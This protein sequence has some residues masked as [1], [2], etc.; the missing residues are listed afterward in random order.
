MDVCL[1]GS[2][3][4]P[5]RRQAAR[6]ASGFGQQCSAASAEPFQSAV[7]IMQ[8]LEA[9][10]EATC[11]AGPTRVGA[12]GRHCTDSVVTMTG[13]PSECQLLIGQLCGGMPISRTGDRAVSLF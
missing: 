12:T 8:P 11:R 2:E 4:P 6:W 3:L 5:K 9:T 13:N 1:A 10:L 7:S